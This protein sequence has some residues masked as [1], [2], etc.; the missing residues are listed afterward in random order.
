M[1]KQKKHREQSRTDKVPTPLLEL[2]NWHVWT[3][4]ALLVAVF[5]HKILLGQGYFWEDFLY[6]NYPFRNFAATSMAMGEMPL[7]NPYTFNGMPFLADIQTTVLYL[8]CLILMFFVSDGMLHFYWLQVVIILHYVL[9]GISMSALARSFG[10]ARLPSLFAGAA[11][12]LSGFMITHAIHQQIITVVAWYPLVILL[13]RKALAPRG[14]MWVFVAALVLG[15]SILAG[16]PQLTLYLYFFLLLFFL[17]EMLGTF[18]WKELFSRAALAMGAR[19]GILVVLSV[20]VAMVQL[21]PTLELSALSQRAE[22]TFEKAMEGSLAWSQLATVF[23]PKLF[24][25]AGAQGY[26]YWGPGTYWYYWETCIY[27]GIL[28]VML[29][30]LSL[31]RVGRE[32]YITF[33][34]GVAI[35]AVLFSL[36]GNFIVHPVFYEIVPGFDRFRN[37]ARM[38]IFLSLAMSLLAAFS[39]DRLLGSGE[40]QPHKEGMIVGVTT[41]VGVV[42]WLLLAAGMLHSVIPA[43]SQVQVFEQAKRDAHLSLLVILVS[44]VLVYLLVSRRGRARWVAPAMVLVF[45]GDMMLFGGD[46]NNAQV[47]PAEYFRRSERL[48]SFLRDDMREEIF[49]VN[50]RNQQGMVVDRNQGMIDRIFMMEGYTPLALQRMYAPHATADASFDLLNVKYKTVA[51][52]QTRRLQLVPHPTYMQRAFMLY[53]IHVVSSDQELI[54]FLQSPA[55]NHRTTAILEKDPGVVLSP[56]DRS[57]VWNASITR[58]ENNR[59]ELDVETTHDGILV[60][61]EIYYPGWRAYVDGS[62]AELFRT[63]YH[64]R[65]LM[66]NSG[67]HKVEVRFQPDSYAHGMMISIAALLVCGGGVVFGAR[68]KQGTT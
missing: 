50:T 26:H 63:N 37:P 21:L 30:V 39:L 18:G 41:G 66:V 10:L 55:Y 57:P 27:L 5:F 42:A 38:G 65:G 11:Y 17:F 40:R 14:W 7:W 64:L 36:G 52:E 24:G 54:D 53:R 22:I 68:Q 32:R 19:A 16:F 45:F 67:K 56:P 48:V 58:Y 13:F 6:Q 25:A 8:P 60:L 12:M 43:F 23:L 29:G 4:L 59:I 33:F 9:A 2:K 34:W 31:V 47:N 44:G 3:L 35:F 15:H 20:A 1:S 51:D 49:R 46:Q 62:G 61:S 28:P